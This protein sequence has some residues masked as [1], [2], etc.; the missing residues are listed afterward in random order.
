MLGGQ[1]VDF[2]LHGEQANR[3][4]NRTERAAVGTEARSMQL[5]L[6]VWLLWIRRTESTQQGGLGRIIAQ[7]GGA[8]VRRRHLWKEAVMLPRTVSMK[9][10]SKVAG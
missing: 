1:S 7:N 6:R 4:R 2:L 8:W 3:T 5:H 10:L 9:F